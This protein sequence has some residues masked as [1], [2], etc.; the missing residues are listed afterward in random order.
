MSRHTCHARQQEGYF[1]REYF[2]VL[3]PP[4]KMKPQTRSRRGLVYG[5]NRF[6]TRLCA[7][8]E[9]VMN[10]PGWELRTTYL[11]RRNPVEPGILWMAGDWDRHGSH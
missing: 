4:R 2:A 1:A 10:G 3:R 5:S 6:V 9:V 11:R 7:G 8:A